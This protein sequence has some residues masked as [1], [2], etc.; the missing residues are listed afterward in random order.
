ML[1]PLLWLFPATQCPPLRAPER[2]SMT[3]PHTAGA[4]AR[5]PGCR[6]SCNEGSALVG[7]EVVRCTASGEWTASPPVC[8][9]E[10]GRPGRCAVP[11]ARLRLLRGVRAGEAGLK[12]QAFT[13]LLSARRD[14]C[15]GQEK[16]V[17][18]RKNK[19]LILLQTELENL[20][21]P[22]AHRHQAGSEWPLHELH[23]RGERVASAS[24]GRHQ[25]PCRGR[26]V[27]ADGTEDTRQSRQE[28][29]CERR[30]WP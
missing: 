14:G 13:V 24:F 20:P 5:Q 11:C 22:K 2:G 10:C 30:G 21:F 29:A 4:A 8:R 9:G 16:R 3:C 19:R 23:T 28:S 1:T 26:P 17:R 7:P 15:V 6:F 27:E 25:E 18:L 12:G